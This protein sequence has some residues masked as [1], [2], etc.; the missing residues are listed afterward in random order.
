MIHDQ[1]GVVRYIAEYEWDDPAVQQQALDDMREELMETMK[2][3]V[4]RG[5][6]GPITITVDIVLHAPKEWPLA[7]RQEY[8][9]PSVRAGSVAMKAEL[10]EGEPDGAPPLPIRW[11]WEGP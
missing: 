7:A 2:Q 9:A 10:V 5:A 3:I 1:V 11:R 8:Y 6:A 4:E